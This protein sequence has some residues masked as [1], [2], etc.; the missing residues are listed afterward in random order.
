VSSPKAALALARTKKIAVAIVE[1]DSEAWATGLFTE[2]RRLGIR[3]IYSGP[4]PQVIEEAL[5][6]TSHEVAGFRKMASL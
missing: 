2:F 4:T 1:Y 6:G 5:N 3:T